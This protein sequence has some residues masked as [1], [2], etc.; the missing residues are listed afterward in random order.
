M[1]GERVTCDKPESRPSPTLQKPSVVRIPSLEMGELARL[2]AYVK[3]AASRANVEAGVRTRWSHATI[4]D[5][6]QDSRPSEI[7]KSPLCLVGDLSR[8]TRTLSNTPQFFLV[9]SSLRCTS[10]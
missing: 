6:C 1:R 9:A 7:R 3:E 8:T 2:R 4:M 10:I 5:A